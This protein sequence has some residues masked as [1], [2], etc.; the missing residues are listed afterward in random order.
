MVFIWVDQGIREPYVPRIEHLPVKNAAELHASSSDKQ[1]EIHEESKPPVSYEYKKA[2]ESYQDTLNQEEH[3]RKKIFYAKDLMTQQVITL[4]VDDSMRTA[5]KL[6][7]EKRFRHIPVV[8]D[9]E[10]AGVISDRD[11]IRVK[12]EIP[13][14]YDTLKISDVMKKKI[15]TAR[16]ETNI[17]DIA[18]IML[19]ERI[20]AMIILDSDGKIAGIITR[21]DILRSIITHAPLELWG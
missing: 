20:G 9:G 17:R 7:N 6:F 10:L 1:V 16:P 15:L 5:E 19:E 4:F 8:K 18:R 21:T 3:T 12:M 14:D 13:E 2:L 11:L